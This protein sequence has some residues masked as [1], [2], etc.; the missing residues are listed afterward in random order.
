MQ[1]KE[2]N[3]LLFRFIKFKNKKIIIKAINLIKLYFKRLY[4]K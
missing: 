1:E 2:V 4:K 3:K